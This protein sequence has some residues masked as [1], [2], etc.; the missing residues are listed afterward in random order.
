MT[1]VWIDDDSKGSQE[2]DNNNVSH[3]VFISSLIFTN[4]FP[5]KKTTEFV[6]IDSL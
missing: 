1:S 4:S 6:V 5:V 3:I 2:E